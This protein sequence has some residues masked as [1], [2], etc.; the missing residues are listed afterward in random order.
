MAGSHHHALVAFTGSQLLGTEALSLVMY[1][2]EAKIPWSLSQCLFPF[3]GG[4][5]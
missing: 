2:H 5:G 4:N 1:C 3:T